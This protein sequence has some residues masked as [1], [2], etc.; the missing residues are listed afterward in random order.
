[1]FQISTGIFGL[2]LGVFVKHS[3]RGKFAYGWRKHFMAILFPLLV[4]VVFA[5]LLS[6]LFYINSEIGIG[7]YTGGYI[8]RFLFGVIVY[9]IAFY[10]TDCRRERKI[11]KCFNGEE[12][13]IN[14]VSVSD[15]GSIRILNIPLCADIEFVK[16]TLKP[17][18]I[19][20]N[21]NCLYLENVSFDN[22]PKLNIHF[23]KDKESR[24][25]KIYI[26]QSNLNQKECD[27]VFDYFK[28]RFN[29]LN[30]FSEKKAEF[31]TE[32][33]L[34]N[35]LHKVDMGKQKGLSGDENK[36]PFYMHIIGRLVASENEK[37]LK[38]SIRQLYFNKGHMNFKSN[39]LFSH[40]QI[41]QTIKVLL[42][43]FA[44]LI[45]YLFTLN[46][47]YKQFDDGYLIIDNWTGKVYETTSRI[48]KPD[49]TKNEQKDD[50]QSSS[51]E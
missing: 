48:V 28:G 11:D 39:K 46:G 24:I 18:E 25:N 26:G 51:L 17:F 33:V 7:Y 30:M 37:E 36:Y 12:K 13:M 49:A 10:V 15:T 22:L 38:H 35:E 41:W 4:S 40:I 2:L 21:E 31:T 5:F 19:Q 50:S 29:G 3:L 14:F 42:C 20:E 44:L 32:V 27:L 8:A 9:I 34:S 1:M 45:A 47:R 23:S 43:A 6:V 16:R